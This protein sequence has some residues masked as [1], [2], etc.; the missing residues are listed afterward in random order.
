MTTHPSMKATDAFAELGRIHLGENDM[1]QVLSRISELAKRTIPGADEVSVSLVQADNA[2]T[3]A[4]TGELAL[5]LDERQ[6]ETGRGP[7]LAAAAGGETVLIPEMAVEDRW[8]D[9]S[10]EALRQGALSSVS[11]GIPVQQAVSGALNIYSTRVKA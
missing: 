7:C 4:F 10:P 8:P 1:T 6:Y 3:A 11:V 2:T 5:N 9:Y